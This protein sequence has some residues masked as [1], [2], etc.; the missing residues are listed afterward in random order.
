MKQA[1]LLSAFLL[2]G[3]ADYSWFGQPESPP[4]SQ[5]NGIA[6]DDEQAV[7]ELESCKQQARAMIQ[8]D[9][10][11]DRDIGASGMIRDDDADLALMR[12]MDEFETTQRFDRIVADCMRQRGYGTPSA[13]TPA[14]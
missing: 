9:A 2:A 7:A 13:E 12:N 8:R 14:E 1:V 10:L 6:A 5:W 11:I 4:S 3:C